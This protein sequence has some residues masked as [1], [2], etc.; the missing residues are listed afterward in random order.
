MRQSKGNREHINPWF[1]C[2]VFMDLKDFFD[3][4][5]TAWDKNQ[6]RYRPHPEDLLNAL[7]MRPG[8]DVLEIGCGSGWL[9]EPLARKIAPGRLYGLDFSG[10]MLRKAATRDMDFPVVIIHA[11]AEDIP[12]PDQTVDRVLMINTFSQ[13]PN[14]ERVISETSRVLRKGGRL[15]IKYFFSRKE[16]SLHHGSKAAL[17]EFSIPDNPLLYSWFN[18]AGFISMAVDRED[19]FH[20]T[21]RLIRPK[22]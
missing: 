3:H 6:A 19:G 11:G 16:I 9:M 22:T 20:F 12:L 15:D 18:S 8:E 2:E 21:S 13:F 14:P 5:A 1:I 4:Q 7:Q 10:E 17:K